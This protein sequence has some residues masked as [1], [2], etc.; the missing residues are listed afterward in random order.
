MATLVSI[1][2][3]LVLFSVGESLM[4]ADRLLFALHL[5]HAARPHLFNLSTTTQPQPP[6]QH[7]GSGISP[8]WRMLLSDPS[9]TAAAPVPGEVAAVDAP[10]WLVPDQLGS[11]RGLAS[12]YPDVIRSLALSDDRWAKWAQQPAPEKSFPPN[13]TSPYFTSP[14]LRLLLVRVLRPDRLLPALQSFVT[15]VLQVESVNPPPASLSRLAETSAAVTPLLLIATTGAD[16]T[17]E[18]ADTAASSVGASAYCEIA[19]GGG[20]QEEALRQLRTAAQEGRWLCLKNLHLVTAFLASLDKELSALTSVHPRFRLWLTAEAHPAFPAPL[21]QLC[22]KVTFEAP[23]GVRNNIARTLEG[24]GQATVGSGS[25][26]R[27]QMLFLL[28]WLHAVVQER[29]KYTPQGWTKGYEFSAADL[30]SG[31]AVLDAMLPRGASSNS[32]IDTRVPWAFIHGL[33]ENTVYGGRVDN[34]YDSRVLRAY[35]AHAL[36][37]EVLAA[38]RQVARGVD[39]PSST[40]VSDYVA[41]L[42]AMPDVDSPT[43][44]ALP[45]NIDRSLQRANCSYITSSLR[46]ITDGASSSTGFDRQV[47]SD[48]LQP[49]VAQWMRAVAS[50]PSLTQPDAEG[51]AAAGKGS[52]RSLTSQRSSSAV[53]TADPLAAFVALEVS[54]ASSLT[55]LVHSDIIAIQQV[56]RSGAVPSSALQEVGAALLSDIVPSSWSKGWTGP[57]TPLAWLSGLL[58]R[59][60]ALSRWSA[61]VASRNLLTTPLALRDLFRPSAF[62]NALR[63]L[64][65]RSARAASNNASLSADSLKLV[66]TWRGQQALQRIPGVI[67]VSISKLRL[68][69]AAWDAERS[70]FAEVGE[71]DDEYQP[72]PHVTAAWVPTEAADQINSSVAGASALLP[73]P[74]Y[75]QADRESL[76][77]EIPVPCGADKARWVLGGTAFFVEQ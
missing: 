35:L 50:D 49:L 12:A 74:L 38:Q 71:T 57:P 75:Q 25:V 73:I 29:R 61:A 3:R 37:P 14:V 53:L 60:S 32:A 13:V 5:I 16:P 46:A 9:A 64:S 45:L 70:C 44:F 23:P 76:I 65:A 55:S 56:L 8:A 59:R 41:R 66:F 2:E 48:R 4:K 34:A 6:Q 39:L 27:A 67:A 18:L 54:F 63:Q 52:C 31:V 24:W 11:Y 21:L 69:G 68:Q 72:V 7:S 47:W 10:G 51:A 62:L 1:L 58:K 77:T 19:M 17:R 42:A 40:S 22:R 33:L 36:H 26:T 15:D 20:Q 30:R 28:S 43:L